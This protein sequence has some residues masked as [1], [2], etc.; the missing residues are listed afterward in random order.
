MKVLYICLS[1]FSLFLY[2]DD[3]DN[4]DS[5]AMKINSLEEKYD[6]C[7][8]SDD[9]VI[10]IDKSALLK[11][12]EIYKQVIIKKDNEILRLKNLNMKKE[13]LKKEIK[14]ENEIIENNS[15]LNVEVGEARTYRLSED[16]DIYDSINGKVLYKWEKNTS[17]TSNTRGDYWIL[18]TGY[19]L[20]KKWIASKKSLWIKIDKVIER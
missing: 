14:K 18:I 9:I 2:A 3:L 4:I 6:D 12:I 11:E 19:F 15:S 1:I 20:D 16:S 7:R 8:L 5:M 13:C 10:D 17:F